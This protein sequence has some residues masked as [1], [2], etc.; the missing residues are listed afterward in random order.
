VTLPSAE[1]VDEQERRRRRTV[2]RSLAVGFG[3]SLLGAAVVGILGASGA[4]SLTAAFMG[5][6]LT[7]G[8]TG[9]LTLVGAVRDE[10]R[11]HRVP[12]GRIGLGVGLLLLAPVLLVLAAGAAAG[13]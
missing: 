4:G 9:V 13:A 5:G 10:A 2:W 11:G 7:A 6:A 12:R 3:L 8:V 1:V